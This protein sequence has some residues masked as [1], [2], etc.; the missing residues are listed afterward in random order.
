MAKMGSS[1]LRL[2]PVFVFL[3]SE[4]T[5]G[6]TKDIDLSRYEI[7]VLILTIIDEGGEINN[8]KLIKMN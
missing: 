5:L 6:V 7:G 8:F 1:Y 4:T 2:S 3:F